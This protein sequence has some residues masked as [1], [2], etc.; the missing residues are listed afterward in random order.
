MLKQIEVQVN[1]QSNV[2]LDPKVYGTLQRDNLQRSGIL[3]IVSRDGIVKPKQSRPIPKEHPKYRVLCG[4]LF[5][6]R[7][8]KKTRRSRPSFP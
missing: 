7:K 6:K 2:I 4:A 1:Q 3:I 5:P 8:Y